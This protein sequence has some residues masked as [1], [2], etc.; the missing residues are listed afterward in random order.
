M[1]RAEASCNGTDPAPLFPRYSSVC[2]MKLLPLFRGVVEFKRWWR[3]MVAKVEH[4]QVI[5]QVTADGRLSYSYAF[6]VT[7]AAAIAT[8]G[9]LLNSPAVIVGAMLISPLMGPITLS[10][11]SVAMASPR[12]GAIGATSLLV[13][14]VLALAV[15]IAIVQLSPLHNATPEIL[16]RTRPNLFDLLVA[17]FAGLAGAYAVVR[18]RGGAIVGV[19]IA[20]ALMP[21]LSVVGFGI[22]TRSW[23]IAEGAGLMFVTNMFA[24]ALA[25]AFVSTWYGFG[26]RELR[27]RLVWQ[28]ALAAVILIPLAIPL[29]NT[30]RTIADEAAVTSQARDVLQSLLAQRKETRLLQ[31]DVGFP[32]QRPLQVT[33]V[34]FASKADSALPADAE[35]ALQTAMHRPVELDLQQVASNVVAANVQTALAVTTQPV[36]PVAAAASSPA[37]ALR[38]AF[39]LPVRL[40]DVDDAAKRIAIMPSPSASAPLDTLQRMES[41][42]GAH[43][44]DWSVRI[45][46]PPQPLLPVDFR[47]GSS[48]LNAQQQSQV[49]SDIWALKAWQIQRVDVVGHAS[50]VGDSRANKALALRR[51]ESVARM[52]RAKGI[53]ARTMGDFPAANQRARE[54]QSGLQAFRTVEIRPSPRP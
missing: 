11:I 7:A 44:P 28:T 37:D 31:F 6:M 53:D 54:R 34:V 3:A 35:R 50:S 12:R 49:A 9:L 21:P 47:A 1:L 17:I 13:G 10:G 30:L 32:E 38:K 2:K 25:V 24:I 16:A 46:P 8:I 52:L 43:Y 23:H 15:S 22:A 36:R 26:R 45:V 41:Q 18:G 29:V 48:D 20:T 5:D 33:A 40:L 27:Q 39:P 42:L 51:A 14:I 19:A 4:T